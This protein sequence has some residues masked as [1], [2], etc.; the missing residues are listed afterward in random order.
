[1]EN[2]KKYVA[3]I[4]VALILSMGLICSSSILIKGFGKIRNEQ[5]SITVTGSA[6]KQIKSDYIDWRSSFGITAED[7][8]TAYRELNNRVTL[9]KKYFKDKGVQESEITFSSI[10]L[11]TNY[12]MLENGNASSVISGYSVFQNINIKST[13][14]DKI[15]KISRE[16]TELL[17]NGIAFQSDNPQYYYRKLADVKIEMIGLATKNAKERANQ[18]A[19]NTGTKIGNLNSANMG[20]FQ[21]TPLYSTE[22]SDYGIN[23]TS[24]IDKE[25]TAV[26]SCDFNIE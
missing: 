20:V 19:I 11:T 25:I 9:V 12:I 4:L 10:S 14:V 3:W 13:D 6:K 8:T 17:N 2:I 1:V 16:S 15:T 7:I 18:M 26:V 24:S 21:I 23:D 22:A 5:K